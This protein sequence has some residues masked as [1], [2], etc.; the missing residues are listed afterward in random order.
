[1][2]DQRAASLGQ[3]DEL[4]HSVAAASNALLLNPDLDTGIQAALA[5]L[6]APSAVDRVHIFQ[7]HTDP[8]SGLIY[9][10]QRYERSKEAA[11]PQIDNPDLQNIPYD[12]VAPRWYDL[13][14]TNQVVSGLVRDFPPSEQEILTP[15][16]ILSLLVAPIWAGTHFWG[17][18]GFDNCHAEQMW[19][20]GEQ[21]IL[22]LVAA[23]IGAAIARQTVDAEN[24][25]QRQKLERIL[26]GIPISIYEKDSEGRYTFVN[27]EMTRFLKRPAQ[28]FLNKTVH[29]VFGPKEAKRFAQD[30]FLLRSGGAESVLLE[31]SM[32]KDGEVRWILTGKSL[33]RP[34]TPLESPISGFSIDVTERKQAEEAVKRQQAFIRSVID[35]VPNLISV[36]DVGGNFLLANRTFAELLETTVDDLLQRNAAEVYFNLDDLA[37]YRQDDKTVLETGRTLNVE[38]SMTKPDG[39]LCW[40][41]VTK[42]PLQMVDGSVC[43]LGIGVDITEERAIKQELRRAKEEAEAATR[44]KSE[45]LAMMSHEIRTPMNG[46]IGMTSL[47]QETPLSEEQQE[48]VET[49]R[50]SGESLLTIINDILD[51]SKMESGH[52]TLESQPFSLQKMIED[53]H[54]LLAARPDGRTLDLCYDLGAD[55]PEIVVGDPTRVRQVL[56]NLIGNALK[57]TNQGGV[58]TTIRTQSDEEVAAAGDICLRISVQDTGI[59][60]SAAKLPSLFT[61]FVQLDSANTRRFE[62]TGLGLAICKRLIELMGGK[63]WVESVEQVGSTFHFTLRVRPY[64]DSAPQPVLRGTPATQSKQILLLTEN[65]LL[66]STLIDWVIRAGAQP[67]TIDPSADEEALASQLPVVDLVLVDEQFEPKSAQRLQ[68]SPAARD[69]RWILLTHPSRLDKSS[70][71]YPEWIHKPL[72]WRHFLRALSDAP[73]ANPRKAPTPR[74]REQALLAEQMPLRIL[75]VEDNLINQKLALIILRK[76]GY[77]ADLA[78]NGEEAIAAV[79]R[80]SYD[81]ILMDVLMP[82]LDG[83]EATRRI[84]SLPGGKEPLILAM[85]ANVMQTD[86]RVCLQAG[87]DD[88][89]SK[90]VTAADVRA[91]LVELFGQKETGEWRLATGD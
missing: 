50:S 12:F 68:E 47:L 49:I 84:R 24:R 37:C 21:A 32:E 88:F 31:L 22:Q 45:F 56:T 46:V 69:A 65:P 87:M 90:P 38:Q 39:S 66:R 3:R 29:E 34:E 16:S 2:N 1:M 51:F 8:E 26:N 41:L 71:P 59:G 58:L 4:L 78:V 30:D 11:Q 25:Q 57:F 62:G 10:S 60:I 83:L 15:Q 33:I 72:K 28:E 14:S 53:I 18:I 17:F 70:I 64:T 67:L 40:Y 52:A 61:P 85:T 74:A 6:I 19:S 55:V 48:Y 63:I 86:Q 13:L 77:T 44:A 7:N 75:L 35:T 42:T 79:K 89:L 23:N 54:D 27:E 81:L 82:V 80:Q 20:T 43:V 9:T 73:A 76:F 5:A 91:K 36:K